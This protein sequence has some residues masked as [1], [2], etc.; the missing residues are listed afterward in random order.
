MDFKSIEI[1]I[2]APLVLNELLRVYLPL[3]F[4]TFSSPA[5]PHLQARVGPP[6]LRVYLPL[7]TPCS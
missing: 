7:L 6:V 1:I 3:L 4:L 2:G 5:F